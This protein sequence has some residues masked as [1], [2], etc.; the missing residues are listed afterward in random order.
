ML[1]FYR[2]IIVCLCT[3]VHVG[4]PLLTPPV[5]VLYP[6]LGGSAGRL[7]PAHPGHRG[8]H[9]APLAQ[10]L[11][12]GQGGGAPPGRRPRPGPP[13]PAPPR[14]GGGPG[15]VQGPAAGHP[16]AP[17]TGTGSGPGQGGLRVGSGSG[18]GQGQGGVGLGL[19]L[20]VKVKGKG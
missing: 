8:P 1:L 11:L 3:L 2:I 13:R 7:P 16:A 10:R 6:V 17:H 15:A 14:P 20:E 9:A 5:P 18:W 19:G 12:P 4:G